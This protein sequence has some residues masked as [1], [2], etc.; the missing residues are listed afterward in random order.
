MYDEEDWEHVSEDSRKLVFGLL[1][2]EPSKRAGLDEIIKLAWVKISKAAA[3]NKKSGK[4][5]KDFRKFVSDRKKQRLLSAPYT[6]SSSAMT[7]NNRNLSS[8]MQLTLPLR[9]RDSLFANKDTSNDKNNS[10]NKK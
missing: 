10:N 9:D 8:T 7:T 1:E 2:K 4:F 6:N 5:T 3:S